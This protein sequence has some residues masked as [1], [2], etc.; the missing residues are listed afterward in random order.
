MSSISGDGSYIFDPN[1]SSLEQLTAPVDRADD[2]K[3]N[4][5]LN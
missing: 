4:P 5:T 2:M 3:Y 1:Q